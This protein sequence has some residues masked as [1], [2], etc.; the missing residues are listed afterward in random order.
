MVKRFVFLL[1]ALWM[2]AFYALGEMRVERL[3]GERYF[4]D[5]K[6]WTYHFTYAYP[7][8]VGEDYTCALI[9]DTYQLALNEM[10]QVV[11][12]MFAN[13]PEMRFDGRNE[14]THDFRVTCN[15]GRVLSVLETRTQT[16]GEEGVRYALEAQVFD[17]SG[18]YAGDALT[19]RGVTLIQ[20]GADADALDALDPAQYPQWANIIGGSSAS[21]AEALRPVLYGEFKKL[22]ET[23]AARSEVTEEA[24]L[25]E[26]LPA[27]D[28]Y[29][30]EKNRLVFFIPPMLLT[31]PGF[32]VP[33]FAFTAEE[34]NALLDN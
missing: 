2:A 27:R 26:C 33:V 17:V 18:M 16:M 24:F 32:D 3:E 8:L 25:D 19:L 1:L 9:N 30:D 7:Y 13:A 4:P 34:L 14:V 23:G 11:L 28:F 5:E 20:A 15:N 22:Q 21:M 12:P 10:V 29:T 31:E 6:N